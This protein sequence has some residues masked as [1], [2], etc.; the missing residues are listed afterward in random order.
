MSGRH[1]ARAVSSGRRGGSW[2]GKIPETMRGSRWR[3]LGVHFTLSLV[4]HDSGRE[5]QRRD[6][7]SAYAL[8]L[9]PGR[10][11]VFCLAP[12][13]ERASDLVGVEALAGEIAIEARIFRLVCD[14]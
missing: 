12:R 3:S 9:E 11:S 8:S 1:P 4:A 14:F 5:W 6:W 7:F 2:R 13:I 10:R